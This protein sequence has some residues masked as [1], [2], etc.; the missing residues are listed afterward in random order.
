M[1]EFKNPFTPSFDEI[2]ARDLEEGELVL[3]CLIL[4]NCCS[5]TIKLANVI[6]TT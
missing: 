6:R 2:S 3:N 4:G 5:I 1:V